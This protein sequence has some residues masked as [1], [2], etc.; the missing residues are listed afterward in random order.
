MKKRFLMAGMACLLGLG[1]MAQEPEKLDVKLTGRALF[2]A[3]TFW[4]NDAAESQDG[5]MNDGVAIRDIRVGLKATY[6]KWYF[7]GDVSYANNK[8]SLKDIYL[9]YSFSKE[10]FLR[11]GHYTVPFGL[12]S[13]YSSAKKEYMDEPEG[14]IY[15]PGR[16]IGV[17]HTLYN[18]PLWVQYGAFADNSALSQSTD[19]SGPQGY[20][21]AARFVWRPVMNEDYGFHV[22]F[23]GMHVCAESNE[24]K[25]NH[26]AY[27]KKY[28]TA[29]DKRTATAIDI[30][31]GRWE[32]KFTAEFQGI[33]RNVQLSSQYYWSH[34]SRIGGTGY[35]TDGFYVSARGII[36]NPANYIYNY[37]G[38]GVDNPSDK[39]L[40]LAL[41]YGYLNLKDNKAIADS[42]IPGMAD[43]GRM[44]DLTAGLSFFWNKYVTLRL[45]YHYIHTHNWGREAKKVN[46]LQ[47]RVQYLF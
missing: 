22:G 8:V 14:N 29:V 5:K 3:A 18:Q 13:A 37:S 11:A 17:M 9:Q 20:A 32:N 12:S 47:M 43:A 30:D 27:S 24:G 36:V 44:S 35:N 21:L 7:R 31:D 4:Q 1:A 33:Y 45:N 2:D 15:Q 38:S 10:N 34:I 23:S 26:I 25:H 6:G 41:G 28:L 16:R 39:C 42:Y 40:E 46:V 19:K